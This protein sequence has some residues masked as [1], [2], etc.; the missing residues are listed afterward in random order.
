MPAGNIIGESLEVAFW[1]RPLIGLA[2]AT[3]DN[4]DGLRSLWVFVS[5]ITL[6]EVTEFLRRYDSADNHLYE[7]GPFLLDVGSRILLKDGA[8][9]RL[10]PQGFRDLMVLVQHGCRWLKGNC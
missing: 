5:L 7:F 8:T 3:D 10:T 6:T 9:V 4:L 2:N 1:E